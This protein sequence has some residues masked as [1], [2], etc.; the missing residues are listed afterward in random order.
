LD[1]IDIG[2]LL[3]LGAVV[4]LLAG[5][6]GIG[7]GM[8]MVPFMAI[9]L[10]RLG[11]SPDTVIKVAI[12]TSL[13]TIV[14][15][16]ASSV[17]AQHA[18]G[19][20]RWDL[21]RALA[22]GIML[23]S[24][25]GAQFAAWMRSGLLTLIFGLFIAT[26]ATQMLRQKKPNPDRT[27]PGPAGLFGAGGLIGTASAVLG[28]GGGFLTVP[29]LVKR[30]VKIHNATGTSAACGFPIA[31]AGTAGYIIAGWNVEMPDWTAGYLFVPALI[32]ISLAS[33]LTAPLGVKLAHRMSV[34]RLK[35]FFAFMLYCLA[36]YM[37]WRA[38][39][40]GL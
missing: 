4:G 28:A 29:F 13:A 5:L 22:P 15:T 16:S 6:L 7:G 25:I 21:V 18:K 34:Q 2:W 35:R 24:L 20:V 9:L 11:F 30:N 23:G 3:V 8:I 12:A 27:L 14:F 19:A 1:I 37:L 31:L 36:A 40:F 38:W 33:V 10:E 32:A 17:R 26:M 39:R